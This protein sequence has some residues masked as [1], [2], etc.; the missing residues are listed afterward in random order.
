MLALQ[1]RSRSYLTTL[2]SFSLPQVGFVIPSLPVAGDF[3]G[4]GRGQEHRYEACLGGRGEGQV[5]LA[6]WEEVDT[7]GLGLA[8]ERH[9]SLL[10]ELGRQW[11]TGRGLN[12]HL[13]HPPQGPQ[14]PGSAL[15]TH[16]PFI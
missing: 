4:W 1:G 6:G 11:R 8:S 2:L 13:H 10:G 16:I 12:S 9:F 5:A 7:A 15:D 3:P 14:A